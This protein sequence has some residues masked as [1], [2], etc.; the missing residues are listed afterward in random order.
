MGELFFYAASW[1]NVEGSWLV[2]AMDVIHKVKS[3]YVNMC[4]LS[5]NIN[6]DRS[7]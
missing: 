5:E 2:A 1:S 6:S 7:C 4:S 3:L